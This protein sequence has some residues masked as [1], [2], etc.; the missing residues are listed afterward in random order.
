[1][2]KHIIDFTEQNWKELI[3][4]INNQEVG[5]LYLKNYDERK[6]DLSDLNVNTKLRD[7]FFNAG[8]MNSLPNFIVEQNFIN[9]LSFNNVYIKEDIINFGDLKSLSSIGLYG[10]QLNSFPKSISKYNSLFTLSVQDSNIVNINESFDALQNLRNLYFRSNPKLKSI[11]KGLERCERLNFVELFECDKID[12]IEIE[13]TNTIKEMRIGS[14]AKNYK[15]PL[16]FNKLTSLERLKIDNYE[17][18]V[19]LSFLKYLKNLSELVVFSIDSSNIKKISEVTFLKHLR[20]G[21][22][23]ASY[24][25]NEIPMCFEKL[26]N[27][28]T[29]RFTPKGNLDLDKLINVTQ[30]LHSLKELWLDNIILDKT[31]INRLKK[32]LKIK[33]INK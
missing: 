21:S 1:M 24:G 9:Y 10:E 29:L 13:E 3:L 28:E 33:I 15:I 20:I 18:V 32:Q 31:E 26:Q 6:I 30:Q 8:Y 25:V 22:F 2:V 4:E 23:M 5:E 14:C 19:N 27:L 11:P 12:R 16:G 17:S 7:I